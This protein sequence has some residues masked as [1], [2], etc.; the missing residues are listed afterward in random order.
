MTDIRIVSALLE[1]GRHSPSIDETE[2]GLGRHVPAD[3]RIAGIVPL[4]V[5]PPDNRTRVT[6]TDE[7]PYC[8]FG[9]LDLVFPKGGAGGSGVLVGSNIVLTAGHCAY[10]QKLGGWVRGARFTPGKNETAA[11]FGFSD[12][13]KAHSTAGW[14]E[15]G[16]PDYDIAAFVLKENFGISVGSINIDILNDDLFKKAV[17]AVTGYPGDK[18]GL[19]MWTHAEKIKTVTLSKLFYEIDTES[20]QSGAPLWN[21]ETQGL[22]GIHTTGG[23]SE[24][25]A[26]RLNAEKS[27]WLKGVMS[28]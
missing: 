17:F 1:E 5:I 26:V 8:T 4:K 11:P 19:Q 27:S 22:A 2:G 6:S 24:N 28:S 16:N 12:A 9:K 20:G 18:G 10:D 25:G 21:P 23:S 13:L 15:R 7:W 3:R 14:V